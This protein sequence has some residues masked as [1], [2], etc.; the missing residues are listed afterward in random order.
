MMMSVCG[1]CVC[2]C[3]FVCFYNQ[4]CKTSLYYNLSY[5]SKSSQHTLPQSQLSKC[6]IAHY[7]VFQLPFCYAELFP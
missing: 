2:V 4:K 6:G 5:K 1:V 7:F 3:V